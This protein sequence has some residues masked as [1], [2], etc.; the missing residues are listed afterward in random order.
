M[1]VGVDVLV[2]VSVGALVDVGV[3]VSV[4]ALVG[5]SVG[6]FVGVVTVGGGVVEVV[7]S[8]LVPVALVSPVF[9]AT[10]AG[11]INAECAFGVGPEGA[12]VV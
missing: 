6:V 2:G 1:V 4:G 12:G 8:V 3:A 9:L 10:L 5:V 7:P 11:S